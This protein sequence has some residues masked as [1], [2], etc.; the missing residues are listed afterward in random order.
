MTRLVA[1]ILIFG[2]ACIPEF[3][4]R[5]TPCMKGV[6]A[7]G[8]AVRPFCLEDQEGSTFTPDDALGK[9][10]FLDISTMWCAPC[11]ELGETARETQDEYES[12]EFLYITVL[13][14]DV[15][16]SPPTPQNLR[17]WHTAYDLNT[18]VL[19]DGGDP[20]ETRQTWDAIDNNQFPSLWVIGRDGVVVERIETATDA[21]VR[22][23][24][25]RNL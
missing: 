16:G 20:Q 10:I 22:E 19:G 14:E 8:E 9:V 24:I 21:A 7:L 18:P 6:F 2:T 4:D 25:E 11:R 3:E 12:E 1:G 23:A 15:D 17:E 5:G 13:Q